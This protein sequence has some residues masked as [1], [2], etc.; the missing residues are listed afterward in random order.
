MTLAGE[1]GFYAQPHRALP[2][3]L[4]C[5]TVA[6]KAIGGGLILLTM[7]LSPHAARSQTGATATGDAGVRVVAIRLA[8]CGGSARSGRLPQRHRP[9][10]AGRCTGACGGRGEDR[11]DQAAR[12]GGRHRAPATSGRPG[13]AVRPFGQSCPAI[14]EGKRNVAAGEALGHVARTGVTYGTHVFFAVLENGQAVDPLDV[15]PPLP[16]CGGPKS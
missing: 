11:G 4:C 6:E 12:L 16:R 8:A 10:G 7:L 15:L 3:W 14:A 2:R 5:A 13:D 1:E 9:A